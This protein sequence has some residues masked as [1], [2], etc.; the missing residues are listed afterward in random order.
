MKL[1]DPILYYQGCNVVTK[2]A[3]PQNDILYICLASQLREDFLLNKSIGL[4]ILPDSDL[5]K[6][7]DFQCEWILWPEETPILELFHQVQTLFLNY[8]Q[9]LNDTS[10]L[11]ETLANNSG[12]DELI[13]SASRLLGNPILLVDSAYRVISMASIGE[14]NDIVWQDAL[15]YGY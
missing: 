4:I 13:K 7:L 11:F 12:I 14:I 6:G 9:Q 3:Q 1:N 15:K 10:V 8:K 2:F 5:K